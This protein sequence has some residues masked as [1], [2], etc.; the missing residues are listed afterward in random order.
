MVREKLFKAYSKTLGMSKPFRF[1]QVLS[2]NDGKN[3]KSLTDEIVLDVLDMSDKNGQRFCEGDMFKFRGDDYITVFSMGHFIGRGVEYS[4]MYFP[5]NDE[6][7]IFANFYSLPNQNEF[8]KSC[9]NAIRSNYQFKVQELNAKISE[10]KIEFE[11]AEKEFQE[12]IKDKDY[13]SIGIANCAH[14]LKMLQGD[15]A[16]NESELKE[17]IE[18]T[19]WVLGLVS[20]QIIE[21]NEPK[22]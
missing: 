18:P 15:I 6:L 19:S 3:I 22:I 14:S 2:F 17:T 20:Q 21:P 9:E 11:R 4:H 7:E 8:L 10:S 16:R 13:K 12:L 5:L 1:G